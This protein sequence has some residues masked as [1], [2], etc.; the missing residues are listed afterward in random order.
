MAR[1]FSLFRLLFAF[2]LI[3][4]SLV[5]PAAPIST[6]Q[7]LSESGSVDFTC[8]SGGTPSPCSVPTGGTITVIGSGFSSSLC[9]R[10]VQLSLVNTATG[11]M[12]ALG[13]VGVG[14]GTSAG[15]SRSFTLPT[16]GANAVP[17]GDYRVRA[18][19]LL[20][21]PP[22]PII[23]E[24]ARIL[25]VGR[26]G[27]GNITGTASCDVPP[28]TLLRNAIVTV[29]SGAAQVFSTTANRDGQY[30]ITGA[31]P[32][33][34]YTVRYQAADGPTS[35]GV[36]VTTDGR[37]N[38]GAP[39]NTPCPNPDRGNLTWLSPA[40]VQ[41]T[42]LGA[43]I[44]D[45]IC[46]SG[47][48]RWYRVAIGPGQQVAAEVNDPSF[49][50]TLALF[51]DIRQAADE[52][53]ATSGATLE[54]IQRFTASLPRDVSAPDVTSPDVTSPDVTSPDVTSPDV[55]SPDVT[56][57]DVTSPD[58]TS[59][60]VTSPDV[61][62]P[63]VTSPDV[64][65]QDAYSAAQLQAILAYSDKPGP[66][67]EFVR[68]HTWD[69]T[70]SFY[71]RV[72]GHND[73]FD[74]T[75]PFTL[76]I[77]VVNRDCLTSD[78]GQF[79]LTN[80]PASLSGLP[81]FTPRT[82]ILTN[83]LRFP[84][85]DRA[86]LLASLT[87]F[88]NRPEIGGAVLDLANDTGLAADYAQW[89]GIPDCVPAANIVVGQIHRILERVRSFAPDSLQYVVLAGG[90]HVVPF[91]RL[92]DQAGLS[93]E[94][95]YS[96]A[97]LDFSVSQA[98]L[99]TG[100]FLSQDTYGSFSRITNR[101]HVIPTF[102]VPVGR[103]VENASDIQRMLAAYA[104]NDGLI[105]PTTA[106]VAGYDFLA[107]S[108]GVER[109]DL[110]DSGLSVDTLIQPEGEGPLANT[111]WNADDL[112]AR[113]LGT[114]RYGII[115]INTHFSGNTLLAA[116]LS[117]RM[118]SREIAD[119]TDLRFVN[120]V[121]LSMGC[122]S[123]YN[124]VDPDATA[125]TQP[126]DWAQ[127]FA[128]QGATLVGGAGFQYGHTPL[129]KYSEV[130]LASVTHQ[131]RLFDGPT[132]GPVAIGRAIVEAKR[133]Y[134][135][136][137]MSGI[138]EKSLAELTLYGLPMMRV[139]VPTGRIPRPAPA[140]PVSTTPGTTAGLSFAN[141]SPS[142]TLN[143]H[144]RL[145][146][147]LGGG[148]TTATYFDANY[149]GV[150][151]DVQSAPGQP[152]L[153]R[154]V[155]DVHA[156][157][158][159]ARGA[160][161]LSATYTDLFRSLSGANLFRPLIDNA[162]SDVRGVRPAYASSI[163]GPAQLGF[164]NN[165]QGQFLIQQ[166]FQFKSTGNSVFGT[167]RRYDT[168]AMRVYY[169]N[170]TDASALAG[171]PVIYSTVLKQDP[172][173]A[174][175]LNVDVT[176]GALRAA[177]IETVFATFTSDGDDTLY[178]RWDSLALTPGP[179]TLKGVGFFRHY[180]GSLNLTDT[181]ATTASIRLFIQA[182]GG[183]G[184]VSQS[185][186]NGNL[187]RLITETATLGSPK[188]STAVALQQPLNTPYEA[189]Y[190]FPLHVSAR[191]TNSVS[192]AP[193]GGKQLTF[194]L[195]RA[196]DQ[197]T[198]A[199]DGTA[200]ADL[201]VLVIPDSPRPVVTVAFTEDAGFLGSSDR[202]EVNV[203]QA[204]TAFIASPASIP[205][206]GAA[207]IATL[208]AQLPSGN[209]ALALVGVRITLSDGRRLDTLTDGFGQVLF[210]TLDFEGVQPG[211]Y[212]TTLNFFGNERYQPAT[213]TLTQPVLP[214][215]NH[216]LALNGSG[217]AE[218]PHTTDL[219]LTGDW[220][221]EM[222]F[223]DEDAKGFDHANRALINKGDG[224]A[225]ESPY[226]VLIGN[227][228]IVVGLRSYGV[229]YALTY[230]LHST[231]F[232]PKSWQHMAATFKSYT[233]VL[234]LYLNGWQVAHKL[235]P[236]R[237]KGNTLPI[238]IGRLGPRADKL[239]LGKLDDIRIWNVVRSQSEIQSNFRQQLSG[240]PSGLVANWKFDERLNTFRAYSAVG[241]HT[242]VLSTTGAAFS[243][244]VHP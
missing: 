143:G 157:N 37:G 22:G 27:T 195:G 25:T 94:H 7:S 180:R 232:S 150:A 4:Q 73:A 102:N 108:S 194:S 53:N 162:P 145:L 207:N 1:R 132:P 47:Q 70:G 237:S 197:V 196:A 111:A 158:T 41:P 43:E 9:E 79:S 135:S 75:R 18:V 104:A 125:G 55:T 154:V 90:D 85:A 189:T 110:I 71:V 147:V 231:D 214:G 130:L 166:P 64:T 78:G 138:D 209:R 202:R 106:F 76:R 239:W 186:N 182:V 92:P 93:N 32:N 199:A 77:T 223:R 220:T 168:M 218:A 69:N 33:A 61:T 10:R 11:E 179:T 190:R 95:D 52:M 217:Y 200:S 146:D 174:S 131:L 105:Q 193:I 171:S 97:V 206:S 67:S 103:L 240:T 46:K 50:V 238:Q 210:D 198:T 177:E 60:D 124:I 99:K 17:A 14:C 13:T 243:T 233:R 107:D 57:P 121:V 45:S 134:V 185:T 39:V 3:V 151:A 123:G 51:R 211:A 208:V 127:A 224:V 56:S 244:D 184:L 176:V 31:A 153:P 148:T 156:N 155:T 30:T 133:A 169:S 72:R 159:L 20:D 116:D 91:Q 114:Q 83:S 221:V 38:A 86:P 229:N 15:F 172:L 236:V 8:G 234:T 201:P 178:G 98:S 48:S 80:T 82:V 81:T 2:A 54:D 141:I 49:D 203:H 5:G 230:D 62:S 100:Y 212:P 118:R 109:Q 173:N 228:S 42:Q 222:W 204:P 68:R 35:C 181:G 21:S 119:V 89:D 112:R 152:I 6:A 139:N 191:L 96:P 142:Y 87:A 225:A 88:A 167:G 137:G 59:P 26:T 175:I 170:R 219:N 28:P 24:S 213:L 192:G 101:D 140:G 113:L 160:V 163:F 241:V 161:M 216:S 227:G 242:A 84:S 74:E 164:I 34:T 149:V 58:V 29:F 19:I 235:L 144:D 205:Y 23:V 226:F 117:S 122:H 16:N 183:N 126:I 187:L 40:V 66:A 120:S 129:M 215:D 128:Q 12:I 115:Q 44:T 36:A 65:S 136:G 188:L 165:L 63:D